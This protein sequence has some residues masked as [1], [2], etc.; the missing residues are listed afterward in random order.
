MLVVAFSVSAVLTRQ[1]SELAVD[2]PLYQATINAKLDDLR[3]GAADNVQRAK[4]SAALKNV[5]EINPHL[6]VPW[7][8]PARLDQPNNQLTKGQDKRAP[9]SGRGSPAGA[10]PIRDCADH[11]R[12]RAVSQKTTFIVGGGTAQPASCHD[13]RKPVRIQTGQRTSC[14]F[15]G[16]DEA[17]FSSP[18]LVKRPPRADDE[19]QTEIS[20]GPASVAIDLLHARVGAQVS[21]E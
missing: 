7:S 19:L 5:A 13:G 14:V 1:V 18:G 8:A 4:V 12:N 3:D 20:C 9:D 16:D 6:L 2:L 21:Q 15:W 10:W 17:L 11:R